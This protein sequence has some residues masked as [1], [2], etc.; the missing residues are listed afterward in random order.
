MTQFKTCGWLVLFL[1]TSVLFAQEKPAEKEDEKNPEGTPIVVEQV[2]SASKRPEK[3]LEAPATVETV[4]EEALLLSS[5]TT[6][7]GALAQVKGVDFA[8]GGI[9]LQK[10]STRGFSSSFN[11]RML[12][13]VDGRLSTLPGAGLPQ[14]GLSPVSS[15]D[16][17]SMELVLG[18]AGAL[19]GSNTTAGVLNI[20]TK[21]PWDEQGLSIAGKFGDQDL[22][23]G[24]FRFAEVFN[25]RWGFKI[26]GEYLDADE[27]DSDN[28]FDVAGQNQTSYGSQAEID[29]AI[30]A[31]LAY[32]EQDLVRDYT[33]T[34]SK[35]E[36]SGYYQSD[37]ALFQGTYG[38]SKNDGFG[39]T[40]VGRNR[41]E[42]WEIE[43][44]QAKAVADHWF[45]E[46]THTKEDAGDTYA[47]DGVPAGLAAGL[48]LE[49]ASEA[50]VF[51]NKSSLDDFELQGNYQFGDL[52]VVGGV[53]HRIYEP[54]S[55]GSYLD[56]FVLPNGEVRDISR[57]ETGLYMQLDYRTLED[58]LRLVAAAR[59]DEFTEFDSKFSP[60]FG[61]TYTIGSHVLRA[62]YITSYRV[63]EIIETHL[64]F[65]GGIARGN[66]DGFDVFDLDGNPVASYDPLEAEEVETFELGWRGILGDS[67]VADAVAYTSKYDNFISPLQFIANAGAGTVAVSRRDGETI[68]VLLTYLNYGEAEINGADL[69]LEFYFNPQIT[70]KTSVGYTDLDS[71]S[72]NTTIPDIP[73]NTPEWKYKGDLL[74]K[75]YF[76]KGTFL[77]LG[78]RNVAAYDYLSGRWNGRIQSSTIV[79]MAVGY[80]VPKADWL[81]KLSV[82]NLF[83]QDDTELLGTPAIPRFVTFEIYKKF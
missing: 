13:L 48:T 78:A 29:A 50:A 71:F 23:N 76:A 19:Y 28:V 2:V 16:I 32:R 33:T 42:G 81:L 38:W 8:N 25:D 43:H 67:V 62:N 60:K 68:P 30:A 74:L 66:N 36:V 34:S 69:G 17:K 24:R 49:Q 72:N 51:I 12:S 41:I 7:S 10:I 3:R 73:F 64:F 6:F 22:V 21:S 59:Y 20:I 54:N 77:N 40:N 63:P 39:V 18:P 31:G 35:Y 5:S 80:Q 82:S 53:S 55:E 15:L 44:Y 4:G 75:D 70:L 83:D 65:L 11:S 27:F 52:F 56:D 9:N 61:A 45:F 58:R 46:Y 47:I 79:D 14:G 57:D 37:F 26:T 1:L